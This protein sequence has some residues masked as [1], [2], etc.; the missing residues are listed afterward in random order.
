MITTLEQHKCEGVDINLN[1]NNKL[2]VTAHYHLDDNTPVSHRITG[3]YNPEEIDENTIKAITD[4]AAFAPFLV[5]EAD[6]ERMAIPVYFT[7]LE[8]FEKQ[9]Y[10]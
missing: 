7:G 8:E 3:E 4:E 1:E 2:T 9:L 6:K 10:L 5:V